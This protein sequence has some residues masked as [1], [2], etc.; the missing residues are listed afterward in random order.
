MNLLKYDSPLIQFINTVIDL[1]ILNVLC[2]ICCI[3]IITIGPALT[4]KYDVAMRI[5][6]REEPAVFKPFFKAF[7]ENF[8]Q[9]TIIWVIL[10]FACALLCMDWSWMID[11]GFSNVPVVYFVAASFITLVVLFIIMTIFPIISRFEVTV[12][13]A[14][15]TSV[16]FS[17]VYF[18]GLLSVATIMGFSLYACIKYFRYLPAVI[19]LS[20]LV[21][22]FCLCLI[23]IRGFKKLEEKFADTEEDSDKDS[24]ATEDITEAEK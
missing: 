12:K 17:I 13:E 18:I 1:I 10:L 9:A 11:T 24:A 23:L 2:T 8:K 6:R 5:V 14:F 4:A 15:K 22:E 16:L 7:K 21:V 20:H 3:P 19:V